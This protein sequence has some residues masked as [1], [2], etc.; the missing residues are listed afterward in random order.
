MATV[1]TIGQFPFWVDSYQKSLHLL[2]L[3]TGKC[4]APAAN[5]TF[6][7]KARH[8]ADRVLAATYADG[9]AAVSA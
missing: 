6:A 9:G 1:V 2:A 8:F 3:T 7:A 4:K 5:Y